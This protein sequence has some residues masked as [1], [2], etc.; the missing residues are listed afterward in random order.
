MNTLWSKYIQTSEEL[1]MTRSVRFRNDNTAKWLPYTKIKSGMK[2]I[3]IGCAGGLLCHRVKE[4]LPSCEVYG[5]DRDAGHI[6]FARKKSEELG[7][8]CYFE[9]GD[10]TSL[11]FNDNIFDLSIS[12]TVME[13]VDPERFLR[14]QY[15]ILKDNGIIT[16]MSV[17][18]GLNITLNDVTETPK[19]ELE[20]FERAK[21]ISEKFENENGVCKYNLS[22]HEIIKQIQQAG[23]INIDVQFTALDWYVPDNA[24]ICDDLAEKQIEVKRLLEL[25]YIQKATLIE[26]DKFI[27]EEIQLLIDSINSKYDR[28]IDEYRKGNKIWD[29][30]ISGLMIITGVKSVI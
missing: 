16:V 20:L 30:N 6:E 29:I 23:F 18:S 10:A 5:V 27:Y 3:D 12:H 15:R 9:I 28:R 21:R 8:E 1:Y 11:P 24:N 17:R 7:L 4:L 26:K 14:E 25:D 19:K 13:H 2:I 22:E